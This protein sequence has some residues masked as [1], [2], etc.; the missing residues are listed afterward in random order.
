[1]K[2]LLLFA[3]IYSMYCKYLV[4]IAAACRHGWATIKTFDKTTETTNETR[5]GT[6]T[7]VACCIERPRERKR[8]RQTDKRQKLII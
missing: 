7:F 2:W 1:M 8:E 3:R 4:P 5:G 6:S